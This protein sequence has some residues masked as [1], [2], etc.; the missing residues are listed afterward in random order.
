MNDK[1]QKRVFIEALGISIDLDQL[2]LLETI[3]RK[4]RR[5]VEEIILE[6][7]LRYAHHRKSRPSSPEDDQDEQAD[8]WKTP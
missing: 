2:T 4:Q 3:A 5:S 1:D 7:V 6:A 8:W